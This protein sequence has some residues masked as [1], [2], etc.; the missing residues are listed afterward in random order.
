MNYTSASSGRAS[1]YDA[2]KVWGDCIEFRPWTMWDDTAKDFD[3][4]TAS[5]SYMHSH[6]LTLKAK[7]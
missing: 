1:V 5:V 2:N 4:K 7:P 3:L 6:W